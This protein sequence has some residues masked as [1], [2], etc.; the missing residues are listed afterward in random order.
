MFFVQ[1]NYNGVINGRFVV[2]HWFMSVW[3]RP[4]ENHVSL[5]YFSCNG[6]DFYQCFIDSTSFVRFYLKLPL[7]TSTVSYTCAA[8]SSSG[9]FVF[10]YLFELEL[11]LNVKY[12]LGTQFLN[13]YNIRYLSHFRKEKKH[14]QICRWQ[15]LHIHFKKKVNSWNR[16]LYFSIYSWPRI[17]N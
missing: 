1:N 5:K 2:F 6:S 13:K 11:Q 4:S 7:E 10:S 3:L 16:E 9:T 17:G 12:Y 15:I 14:I 8:T